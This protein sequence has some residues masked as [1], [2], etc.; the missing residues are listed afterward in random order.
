MSS[1]GTR[2]SIS[3]KAI[4][5][6]RLKDYCNS[7]GISV[8]GCI[9]EIVDEKLGAPTDEDRRKFD[10]ILAARQEEKEAKKKPQETERD[11]LENYVPPI[12]FF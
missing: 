10:E 12:Q 6:Q 2:R 4:T 7:R 1:G 5:Y 8:S 3:V 9:E 11:E